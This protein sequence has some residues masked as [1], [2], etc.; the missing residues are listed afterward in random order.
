MNHLQNIGGLKVKSRTSV[1]KYRNLQ[2]DIKDIG[3]DLSIVYSGRKRK[4]IRR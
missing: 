2:K 3:H 1:E 4:K